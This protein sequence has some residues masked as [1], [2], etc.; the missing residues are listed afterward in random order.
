M[1]RTEKKPTR[2]ELL[3][4]PDQFITFS[5]RMIAFG[6]RYRRPLTYAA[7]AAACVLVVF[8]GARYFIARAENQAFSLLD[9]YTARYRMALAEKSPEKAWEDVQAGFEGLIADYGSRAGGKLAR[10]RYAD[11]CY[12][13][14]RTDQAIPLYEKALEDFGAEPFYRALMLNS[15]GY[16]HARKGDWEAAAKYLLQVADLPEAPLRDKA[17]FVLAGIYAAQGRS[18]EAKSAYRRLLDEFSDS[19]YAAVA[20]E[21]VNG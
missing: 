9:Q 21:R 12:A 4:E 20:R 17:L 13:A 18:A 11:I 10:I 2:K 16:A 14:G 15:L 7:V 6:K 3:K 19:S 1:A 5:G 8:T